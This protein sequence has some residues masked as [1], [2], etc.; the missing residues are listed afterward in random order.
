MSHFTTCAIF[1]FES[2]EL[3]NNFKKIYETDKD[4]M[5]DLSMKKLE[6]PLSRF[7]INFKVKPYRVYLEKDELQKMIKNYKEKNLNILAKRME[8]WNANKGGVDEKGLYYETNQNPNGKFDYWTIYDIIPVDKFVSSLDKSELVPQV[9][10]QPDCTIIESKH[11]F[12][13]VSEGNVKNFNSWVNKI[14]NILS[15]YPNSM[16]ALIDCHI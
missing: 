1:P 11:F 13:S 14:K 12:Y 16:I 15:K 7:D 3:E 10:L 6:R 5:I 8:D 4:A 2:K 9:I